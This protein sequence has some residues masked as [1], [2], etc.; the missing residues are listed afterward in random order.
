[1]AVASY[2]AAKFV[3]KTAKGPNYLGTGLGMTTDIDDLEPGDLARF[4]DLNTGKSWLHLIPLYFH[5]YY[6]Q[7]PFVNGKV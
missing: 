4:A 5:I 3:W 2:R 6:I 7:H 1:M